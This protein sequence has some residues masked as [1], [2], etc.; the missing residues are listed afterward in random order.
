[1]LGQGGLRSVVDPHVAID[2]QDRRLLGGRRHPLGAERSAP[3]EGLLLLGQVLEL[4]AQGAHLGNA[5]E[6]QKLSPFPR[7]TVAQC[8]DGFEPCER[9]EGQEQKHRLEAIE[10]RG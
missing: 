8:L 4:G 5:V 2:V 6:P 3:L 10:P 7:R 1:M 9:Q